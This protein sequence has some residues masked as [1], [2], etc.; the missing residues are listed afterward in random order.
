M[1]IC[2]PS[3]FLTRFYVTSVKH[4]LLQLIHDW[5]LCGKW[6]WKPLSHAWLFENPWTTESVEFSRPEYWSLSLLQGICPKPGIEPKSLALQADSLPVE[7]QGTLCIFRKL[8]FPSGSDGKASACNVGDPGLNPRSGRS[9]RGG[10]GN[11]LQYSCLE[12]PMDKGAR[13]ATV[14]GVT[15][16]WTRLS[17]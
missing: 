13:W 11:L 8:D 1:H 7:P 4:K 9:P 16:S 15:K 10:S 6:K 12:N 2:I 3:V 5:I 14:L 17:D